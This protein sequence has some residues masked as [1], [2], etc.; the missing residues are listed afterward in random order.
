MK[1]PMLP[2]LNCDDCGAC[3]LEQGS[4]PGYILLLGCRERGESTD[5]WPDQ[6]DVTRLDELPAAA[7]RLLIEHRRRLRHGDDQGEGPCV[8][9]NQRTKKCRFHDHRP[10][11]CRDLE[12]GGEGCQAWRAE[13]QIAEATP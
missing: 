7:R 5:D 6:E 1:E 4:P 13:Y 3:C 9:F 8:W 2:I 10:Q 12:I 11:I